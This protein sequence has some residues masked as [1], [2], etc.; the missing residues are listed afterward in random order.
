MVV[1]KEFLLFCFVART[2]VHDRR[3]AEAPCE[4]FKS[5]CC[6]GS[7]CVACYHRAQGTFALR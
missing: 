3:M 2:Q 5:N 1:V 7:H 6:T 4:G